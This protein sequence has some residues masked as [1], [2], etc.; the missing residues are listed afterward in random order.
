MGLLSVS[1]MFS[2]SILKMWCFVF[3]N[4]TAFCYQFT[5]LKVHKWQTQTRMVIMRFEERE[6]FEEVIFVEHISDASVLVLGCLFELAKD[7]QNSKICINWL[8]KFVLS[9]RT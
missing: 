7:L 9:K 2:L 3:S 6:T 1:G 4:L 8:E 5:Y